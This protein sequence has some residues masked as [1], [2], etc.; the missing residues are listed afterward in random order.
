MKNNTMIKH[1]QN[2]NKNE[3]P[4][5]RIGFLSD[6]GK[7]RQ[8]DE[9]SILAIECLSAFESKETRK[10]LLVLADGMGGH[11]KG[12]L[13][14]KIAVTTVAEKMIVNTITNNNYASEIKQSILEAN[15]KIVQYATENSNAEGM[16]STIVCAVVDNNEVHLGNVGDSRAY[17]ISE[18]EIRQVTKDHSHV[19]E[20]I[21]RGEITPEEATS[22]PKKNVIT[23][24]LGI[25]PEIEVDTMKLTKADDEILLLCC[26]GLI[27]HVNDEEIKDIVTSENP[28]EACKKL[29]DLANERGGKDNISVIILR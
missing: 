29:V 1:N 19:Q 26:D 8:I 20:L 23:R 17:V 10:F 2:K 11:A 14:S 4:A 15:A 6:V 25:Y 22:H 28:Q 18:E 24:A 13:A 21:D 5:N 7:K 9:D 12:E 16:G 27:I 3:T